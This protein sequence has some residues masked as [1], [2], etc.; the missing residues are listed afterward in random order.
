MSVDEEALCFWPRVSGLK[1][2][3]ECSYERGGGPRQLMKQCSIP[4]NHSIYSGCQPKGG[5]GQ[6]IL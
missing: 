2:A 4:C 3:P 1:N 5:A 6:E